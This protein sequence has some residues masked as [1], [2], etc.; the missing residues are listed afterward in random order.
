MT[1]S[2]LIARVHKTHD[3]T[4]CF[5]SDNETYRRLYGPRRGGVHGNGCYADDGRHGVGGA[6]MASESRGVPA[7]LATT[8]PPDAMRE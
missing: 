5:Y 6:S 3:N 1:T 2:D 4:G 8:V 7:T